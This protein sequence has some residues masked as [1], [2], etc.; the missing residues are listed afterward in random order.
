[1][2]TY[3]NWSKVYS[4]THAQGNYLIFTIEYGRKNYAGVMLPAAM[5]DIWNIAGSRL[6]EKMNIEEGASSDDEVL[7]RLNFWMEQNLSGHFAIQPVENMYP[8]IEM[9]Y[10]TYEA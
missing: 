7:A 2:N 3:F 10:E 1:M 4:V 9:E 5:D 8:P 6:I